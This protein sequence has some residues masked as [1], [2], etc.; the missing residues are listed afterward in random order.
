MKKKVFKLSTRWKHTHST[1]ASRSPRRSAESRNTQPWH[2]PRSCSLQDSRHRKWQQVPRSLCLGGRA[3]GSE[4][5]T[6]SH[7]PPPGNMGVTA[8]QFPGALGS[9]PSEGRRPGHGPGRS[10]HLPALALGL[11]PAVHQ[12]RLCHPDLHETEPG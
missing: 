7:R 4:T 12:E 8:S 9:L 10:P 3:P 1:G 2:A 5:S 6:K 11:L